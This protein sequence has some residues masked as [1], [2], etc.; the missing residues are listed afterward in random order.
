MERL[1][2][3]AGDIIDATVV[4]V[5]PFGLL[6]ETAAG[7]P[8]LARGANADVGA[9]VRVRV[10]EIDHEQGRFSATLIP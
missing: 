6:V 5:A 1:L 2:L 4:K 10:A 7:L 8:G 3:H 9:T